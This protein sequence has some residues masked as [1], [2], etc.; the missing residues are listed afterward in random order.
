MA[1][2]ASVW[3]GPSTAL[4]GTP[5][6][7]F[8]SAKGTE[9]VVGGQPWKFAGYNLPCANS[10]DLSS[11]AL[12]YYL[13]DIQQNSGANTIR[14][15][16]FQSLGGPGNWSGFD[17]VI[18][19]LKARGMRAIVTLAD[20]DS[21]CD[22]PNPPTPDKTIGWYQSG[23]MSPYGGYSLSFHDYAMAVAAHYAD[24]PTV[25]FWQLVNEAQAPSYDGAGN[26]VCPDETAARDALRTFSDTMTA[27]IHSVDPNHLVDLGGEPGPCG[28][29]SDADYSYVHAGA[30]GLCEY[31]DY[32]SPAVP[33]PSGLAGAVDACHALDKPVYVGESGIPANVGPDGTPNS[34]CSPWPSCSPV[35]VTGQSLQ[36]RA[37][38]FT[39]KIQAA[40]NKGVAG[41]VIW[42]KSPYYDTSTEG[43]AIGTDDPT[44]AVLSQALQPY[45]SASSPPSAMPESPWTGGLAICAVAVLGGS[46]LVGRRRRRASSSNGE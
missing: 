9:L 40:N 41:Y 27:A 24:E 17:N 16:F 43:Y 46:V 11:G 12:N 39:A 38:F 18:A 35:P 3:V 8:V 4:A 2:L 21:A 5:T 6:T 44:E 33:L 13:E 1:L 23:Y 29:S 28:L 7:G 32:G 19:A 34:T 36:Q 20:F 14:V 22:E 25:A 26:L 30:L 37:D 15:W 10:T 45:P 31:H 42:V